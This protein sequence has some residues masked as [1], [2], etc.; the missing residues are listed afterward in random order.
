MKIPL[1]RIASLSHNKLI[2][3]E[4]AKGFVYYGVGRAQLPDV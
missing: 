3:P 1:S 2:D 4:A